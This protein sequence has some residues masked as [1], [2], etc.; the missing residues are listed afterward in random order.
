[1]WV[2]NELC[3]LWPEQD[4]SEGTKMVTGKHQ[5]WVEEEA[6]KRSRDCSKKAKRSRR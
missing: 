6:S 4:Y 5:Q 3:V 1:M 2:K